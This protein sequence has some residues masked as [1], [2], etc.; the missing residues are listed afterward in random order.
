MYAPTMLREAGCDWDSVCREVY[1]SKEGS[2]TDVKCGFIWLVEC[3]KAMYKNT[4][5]TVG[6]MFLR[7]LKHLSVPQPQYDEAVDFNDGGERGADLELFHQD[8]ALYVSDS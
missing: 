5:D 1:K 4:G 3:A 6:D 7:H 2:Y 8:S